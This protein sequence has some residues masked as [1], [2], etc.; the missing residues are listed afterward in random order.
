[1][2]RGAALKCRHGRQYNGRWGTRSHWRLLCHEVTW[3]VRAIAGVAS[4]ATAISAADGS[5]SLSLCSS[6]IFAAS[7]LS[8][9]WR[10]E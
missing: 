4:M 7:L 1:M 6:D 2:R 8:R 5:L 9:R 3:L 10:R